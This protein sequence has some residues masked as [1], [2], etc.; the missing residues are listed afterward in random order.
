MVLHLMQM[1]LFNTMIGEEKCEEVTYIGQI[2]Q[3][4]RKRDCSGGPL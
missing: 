2:Q 1:D 4:A 3:D